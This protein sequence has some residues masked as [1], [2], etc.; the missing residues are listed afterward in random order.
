MHIHLLLLAILQEQFH[1]VILYWQLR[2]HEP[3]QKD[4]STQDPERVNESVM[5]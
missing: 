3:I 4:S 2:Q 1:F 5:Q